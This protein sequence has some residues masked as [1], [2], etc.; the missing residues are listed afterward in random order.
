MRFIY[1]T[2][3]IE[4]FLLKICISIK[5]WPVV[6]RLFGESGS[7]KTTFLK[8]FASGRNDVLWISCEELKNL[9]CQNLSESECNEFQ[10]T[11]YKYVIIENIEDLCG[12]GINLY[13]SSFVDSLCRY[14]KT[15]FITETREKPISLSINHNVFTVR[16]IRLRPSTRIIREIAK[17]YSI[18]INHSEIDRILQDFNSL[19]GLESYIQLLQDE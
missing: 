16:F 19:I 7:G 14:G 17:K 13:F 10:F 11:S 8:C 1:T 2:K 4:T 6:F 15:V 9:V 3:N 12:L 18:A 5:T